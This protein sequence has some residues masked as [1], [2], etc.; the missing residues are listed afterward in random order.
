[1]SEARGTQQPTKPVYVSQ[2]VS[3]ASGPPLA[4]PTQART[5]SVGAKPSRGTRCSSYSVTAVARAFIPSS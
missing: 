1:M 2:C 5:A 3:G 4:Q